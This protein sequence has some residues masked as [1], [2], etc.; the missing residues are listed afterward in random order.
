MN[1]IF[2]RIKQFIATRNTNLTYLEVDFV[3]KYLNLQEQI[4]FFR[5]K[6]FDQHHALL[7]AQK[8]LEKTRDIEW[9]DKPKMAKVA[10]LHDI[11]KSSTN[12]SGNLRAFYVILDSFGKGKLLNIVSKQNSIFTLRRKLYILKEHG[13]IGRKMLEDIDCN[14][15]ELLQSVEMHHKKPEVN[16]SKMLPILREIDATL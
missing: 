9:I 5:M 7:V 14:D 15:Y 1:K 4:I 12:I 16:E 8:C 11:G 2:Y 6:G 10:L 3:R 13:R